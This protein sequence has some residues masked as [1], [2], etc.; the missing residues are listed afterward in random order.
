MITENTPSGYSCYSGKDQERGLSSEKSRNCI[1][2]IQDLLSYMLFVKSKEEKS[3]QLQQ[4][5]T[6]KGIYSSLSDVTWIIIIGLRPEQE[7]PYNPLIVLHEDC[8]D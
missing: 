4:F 8:K 1:T 6:K 5:R 7:S 3:R 2:R